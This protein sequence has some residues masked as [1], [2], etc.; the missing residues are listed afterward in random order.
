[1]GEKDTD[2]DDLDKLMDVIEAEIADG[3]SE[4]SINKSSSLKINNN[5]VLKNATEELNAN[6]NEQI[7]LNQPKIIED[8]KSQLNPSKEEHESIITLETDKKS[9]SKCT[10]LKS[11][12]VLK[13]PMPSNIKRSISPY[14]KYL[15]ICSTG[16]SRP[17][18]R[19]LSP[20]RLSPIKEKT[21]SP[22]QYSPPKSQNPSSSSKKSYSSLSQVISSNNKRQS[23]SSRKSISPPKRKSK[24]PD[25]SYANKKSNN[26]I[27]KLMISRQI[28][29][30]I[31]CADNN[32]N[33]QKTVKLVEKQVEMKSFDLPLEVRKRT[34]EPNS[35]NN[36][37]NEG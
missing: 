22:V 27:K 12:V 33:F 19:S 31:R 35:Y 4:S 13:S 36:L 14:T 37:I 6:I 15:N 23:Q 10:L 1:L 34:F 24:S 17:Q 18:H 2:L 16:Q 29:P 26:S 28:S 30:T 9:P 3:V 8:S 20:R 7:A 11:C 5:Y 32:D 21:L 25:N